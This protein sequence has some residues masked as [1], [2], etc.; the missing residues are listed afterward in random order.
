MPSPIPALDL[1][2]SAMR[3][4]GSLASGETPTAPEA[5][6]GLSVLNDMLENWSLENLTVWGSANQSFPMVP[7]QATYTIGPAGNFNTTRPVN[8]EAAYSTFGGVDFPIQLI[9]QEEYNLINLKIMQQPIVERMLYVNEYP[10]GQLTLWPVPNQAGPLT[11][12]M[13]RVL[14]F[15]VALA[16]SLSGPPGY[17]KA[18]RYCLAIEYASE[19][20]IEVLPTVFQ[21]AADAKADF[22]RANIEPV[23]MRCDDAL[24]NPPVALYQRGY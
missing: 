23:T 12:S 19:F 4:N 1:I 21:V 10:L 13:S 18:L 11:L 5:N 3:L 7:G 6:D 2:T 24:V 22:K 16:T 14:T 15:P 9:T 17:L 20:G 8:I